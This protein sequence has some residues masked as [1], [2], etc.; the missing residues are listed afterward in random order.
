[1]PGMVVLG[2]SSPAYW[3][4]SKCK[5]GSRCVSHRHELRLPA[6]LCDAICSNFCIMSSLE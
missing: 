3:P 1:M 5:T 6:L 4:P 2:D